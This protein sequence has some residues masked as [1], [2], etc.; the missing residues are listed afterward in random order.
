[1]NRVL[2]LAAYNIKLLLS[3]RNWFFLIWA[4]FALQI[5][6]FGSLMSRLVS[7]KVEDYL[8]FYGI[9]L[10][11]ITVFDSGATVGRNFVEHAHE[12]ELPYFL[13][14]PVS[15]RGFL[16][17]QALYGVANTMIR[18]LP[19]LIGVLVFLGRLTVQCVVF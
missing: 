11:V 1:M 13:S 4:L 16:A 15:R 9:G 18:V 14:L 3:E 12:G 7:G 10:M 17:A 8:F 6:I 19:P 5:T 2:T